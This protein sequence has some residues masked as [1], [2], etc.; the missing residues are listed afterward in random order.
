MYQA[1]VAS[2]PIEVALRPRANALRRGWRLAR[3]KPA[4]ALSLA[5]VVLLVVVAAG[6]PILAPADPTVQSSAQIMKPPSL[7]A[8]M[9]TDH[10]GRDILSRVIYGAQVSLLVGIVSVLLG[11]VVGSL[12]GL[13]SGYFEGR[14]DMTLQRLIDVWMAFPPLI[15][16]LTMVAA[17]GPSLINLMIAIGLSG[18]PR[19]NRVVRGTVLSEKRNVYLEAARVVGCGSWRL[20]LRHLLPNVTAPIL[21]IATLTLGQA[22]LAEASLSFLGLGVPP[23]TPT[24]GGMLSSDA[25]RYMLAGPWVAIFPGLAITATVL[26]W[27]L[28]GDALRDVWDPRLRGG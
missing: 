27:N 21:I 28:L 6:A 20:M 13:V 18:V 24:W 11:T 25:R 1:D 14:L 15:F 2:L 7:Q 10:F 5:V 23:P 16:A 8:L 12:V 9:G 22:I 4:G 17:L 3:R 19:A 26:A